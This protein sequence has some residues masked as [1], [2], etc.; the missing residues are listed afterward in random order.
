MNDLQVH[1]NDNL[2]FLEDY[3]DTNAETTMQN[4]FTKAYAAFRLESSVK[5]MKVKLR[6]QPICIIQKISSAA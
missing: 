5:M 6:Q 4:S 2:I 1:L 3:W